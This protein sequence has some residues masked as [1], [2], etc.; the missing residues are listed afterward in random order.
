M[1]AF[2]NAKKHDSIALFLDSLLTYTFLINPFVSVHSFL[3]FVFLCIY[4]YIYVFATSFFLHG[5]ALIINFI[6]PIKKKGKKKHDIFGIL[7]CSWMKDYTSKS[8]EN[9]IDHSVLLIKTTMNGL[10]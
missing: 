1:D 4:I 5:V 6:L 2:Y 3:S 9:F 7:K 8:K 10:F